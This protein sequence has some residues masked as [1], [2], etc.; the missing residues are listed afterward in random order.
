MKENEMVKPTV[1]FAIAAIVALGVLA[2][3]AKQP[4]SLSGFWLVDTRHSDAQLITDGTR[5]YGKTKIDITLGFAR[6]EGA[7]RFDDGDPAN[8]KVDLHI[9]PAT[10]M[11][12]PLGEEGDFKSRWLANRANN[13]LL[14]FHS[15]SVTRRSDGRLQ[16]QGDLTLVR[17]DRNVQ[18]PAAS[19]AYYGPVYGPPII[20][21]VSREATLIFDAAVDGTAQKAG[22]IGVSA[23]TKVF[24]EDFPQI[25]KAAL[26]TYWPPLVQD[27]N[28]SLPSGL[29]SEA[30]SGARCTGTF[31]QG[32]SLP[33]DPGTRIGEDYPGS[34]NSNTQVGQRLNILVHLRLQQRDAGQQM[35][36]GN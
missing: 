7:I 4:A 17:V 29:P 30:Y 35:V 21:R 8:S 20:N 31:M 34:Q 3:G 28:C 11:A 15:K 14:C 9:Y 16:T 18:I 12:P 32:P 1:L 19:E 33:E 36:G 24:R 6:V 22:G 5:D 25:V 10:S 27:E 13:T 26:N 2:L 23:S